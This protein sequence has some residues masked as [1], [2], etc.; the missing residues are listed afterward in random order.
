[1]K[2]LLLLLLFIP[3]VFSCSS[4]ESVNYILTVKINPE[5]GGFVNPN[6]GTVPEGQQISLQ[7]TASPY[8]EF[9]NWSGSETGISSNISIIMDDNKTLIAN[10]KE[11]PFYVDDNGVTIKARDWVTVGTTG[12]LNGVTYTAVD[13][14]TLKEMVENDEDVT[15][16]VTTLV[17]DMNNL[18]KGKEDFNGDISSWDVSSVNSM[19]AMFVNA[20]SFNQ[21]IGDWD[22]GNVTLMNRMFVNATSFNQDIG[23][24]DISSVTRIGSMFSNAKNFNQDIGDWDVSKVLD[25]EFVFHKSESFNQDIGDWKVSSVTAMNMM[26]LGAESFNQPI[27]SWDVSNVEYMNYMF[28]GTPFNQDIGEWDVSSVTQMGWMFYN[29]QQFNQDLTKWC[30]TKITSEPT[31]FSNSSALTDANKP[32]WGTCPSD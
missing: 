19:T 11:L 5:G 1:M 29:A 8:Y 28:S 6:G 17:T 2:K 31:D 30:V 14:T 4:E 18:F 32:K 3:L 26:F 12:E 25:M 13:D 23:D 22:T 27:E 9:E 24:W 21:D 10:F 16:V 7:A 15:K 20:T